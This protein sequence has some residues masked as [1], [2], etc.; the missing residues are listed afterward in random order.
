MS[1]LNSEQAVQGSAWPCKKQAGASTTVA[2]A[3]HRAR[4]PARPHRRPPPAASSR[5]AGPSS[6][7]PATPS[8]RRLPAID[9]PRS[10]PPASLPPRCMRL[11][12]WPPGGVAAPLPASLPPRALRRFLQDPSVV[13]VPPPALLLPPCLVAAI[14]LIVRVILHQPERPERPNAER[15]YRNPIGRRG[16]GWNAWP[17]EFEYGHPAFGRSG[18][19]AWCKMTLSIDKIRKRNRETS[20][21]YGACPK[22]ETSRFFLFFSAHWPSA[23]VR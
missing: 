1:S 12:G 14:V 20:I 6:S 4:P 18:R 3:L 9:V 13:S 16:L 22:N 5:P 17:M 11:C 23:T 7:P 8:S 2:S 10:T 15:R 19:S 21:A